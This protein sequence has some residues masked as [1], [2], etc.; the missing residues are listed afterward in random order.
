LRTTHLLTVH[1]LAGV[2]SL[3]PQT[4]YRWTKSGR[5]P[6]VRV[7]DLLRFPEREVKRF[8][9]ER[10]RGITDLAILYPQT[11][12]V[13]DLAAFDRLHLKPK[14]GQSAVGKSQRRWRYA[15]GTIFLRRT[16]G[17]GERYCVDYRDHR[18][19]RVREVIK[20]ARTR[21]E[22]LAV[23]QEKITTSFNAR[24]NPFRRRESPTFNRLAEMYLEDYA[25]ANKKSWKCDF[26]ALEAHLKPRFGA[27]RLEE[28]TPQL[29]EQYKG[30]RLKS[31]R[32]SSVNR[33]LAL[34]KAMFNIALD[35]GCASS[36][37]I[38]KIE[39]FPE[40]D[41]LKQRVLSEGEEVR[42]LATAAPHLR[43][44]IIG[45]LN[46]G[47]RRNELLTLRWS[48]VDLERGTILLTR[49]KGGTDRTIPVNKRLMDLLRGLKTGSNGGYVFTGPKGE[50][51]RTIRRAFQNACRR[52]GLT[53]LRIHD[54]R[55]T[56]ATRLIRSGA[57]IITVKE[58]LGHHSV[59]VT[60]RY[61]H[62][63]D[64]RRRAAVERLAPKPTEIRENLA[65]IWHAEKAGTNR[66]PASPLF[67][68]N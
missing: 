1:E 67:S 6:C 63:E 24:H 2:F 50:R 20:Q 9:E 30:E 56:F 48:E 26:Y 4:I 64:E 34:L 16:K 37:P 33:E 10:T 49:T 5:L 65:P 28:I 57:D 13:L 38:L 31:V 46:T 59:V 18:G 68:V 22:A 44:V 36:N 51:I 52:A 53:G 7:G 35:W 66:Q 25:K 41:N 40:R 23:L 29:V 15:F 61:T 17:R 12:I 43:A 60:E 45:L 55:H 11:K 47:A 62:G 32:K 14:G 3:H 21:A 39:M 19:R 42:L 54:L 8:L 58:L 27:M